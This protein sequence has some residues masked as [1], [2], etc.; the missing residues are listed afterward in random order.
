[1]ATTGSLRLVSLL[2]SVTEILG[3]LG[4]AGQIVGI[5]HECDLCPDKVGGYQPIVPV[6]IVLFCGHWLKRGANPDS[7]WTAA[8]T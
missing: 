7:H 1:M 4:L 8:Y 2:P 6:P 5:T 3:G